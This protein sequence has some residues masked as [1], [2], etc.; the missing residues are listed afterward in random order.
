M[1]KERKWFR[2]ALAIMVLT[3]GLNGL[4]SYLTDPYG[5]FRR[6]FRYQFV[7]PDLN[8]IKVQHLL[9]HPERYDC[10]VFGSSRVNTIDVRKIRGYR[11]YNMTCNGGLPRDYLDNVRY[12][13]KKGMSLRM[14]LVGLDDFDFRVDP[15]SHL[16]QPSRH[17][18]P[19]VVGQPLLPFYLKNLFSLH[20]RDIIR[21]IVKGYI[22]IARG[23]R[24]APV[25]YDMFG[26]G[27]NYAPWADAAI[28][29][30]PE[31]WRAD[32]RFTTH[33]QVSGDNMKGVLQDLASLAD[34][35]RR[36]RIQL[37]LFINPLYKNVFVD[38]GLEEFSRFKRE[39]VE[40]ADFYDF[41][42]INTVTSDSIN[43]YDLSHFTFATGDMVL[44]RIFR[45]GTGR[46]APPDFGVFV[47]RENIE[48]HL[49]AL[50]RGVP[51]ELIAAIPR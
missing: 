4:F 37:I 48:S 28:E 6:D 42:G 43:Y 27:Q 40:I 13:L 39:L 34:V 33:R 31:A 24:G 9:A 41:S 51:K 49:L 36:K 35:A 12:L 17:P 18:Y 47:T 20:D 19:P 8:F 15:A 45:D 22:A 10:L 16:S 3:L 21:E 26:T 44:G 2:W 38:G 25:L 1:E 7:E 50:R 23:K 46:M 32:P 14:I 29:T 11:C 5:L 30:A